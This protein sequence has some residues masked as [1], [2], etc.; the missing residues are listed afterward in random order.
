MNSLQIDLF[1][2]IGA[3]TD[4]DT[5]KDQPILMGGKC[6]EETTG[7]RVIVEQEAVPYIAYP[8][9]FVCLFIDGRHK[10]RKFIIS[11]D[12]LKRTS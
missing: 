5:E 9:H 10:G 6:V 12:R 2:F 3:D 11:K 4:T 1:A 7:D 8:N